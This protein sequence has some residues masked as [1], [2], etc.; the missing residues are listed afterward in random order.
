VNG[1]L[2]LHEFNLVLGLDLFDIFLPELWDELQLRLIPLRHI[3]LL[4]NAFSIDSPLIELRS[5]LINVALPLSLNRR[6]LRGR[7]HRN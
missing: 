2:L 1:I 3:F 4:Q 6:S 5:L 7:W